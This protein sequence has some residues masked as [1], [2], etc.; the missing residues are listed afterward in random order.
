VQP[1]DLIH[2]VLLLGEAILPK[3]FILIK[4]LQNL[5]TLNAY[6][7]VVVVGLFQLLVKLLHD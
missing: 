4:P 2:L 1:E 6:S 5:V 3:G 7:L